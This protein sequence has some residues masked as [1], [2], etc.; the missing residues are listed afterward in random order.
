[1]KSFIDDILHKWPPY[2]KYLFFAIL[3]ATGFPSIYIFAFNDYFYKPFAVSLYF[4][5]C[6]AF[7]YIAENNKIVKK[8]KWGVWVENIVIVEA[9]LFLLF[10]QKHFIAAAIIVALLIVF[11]AFLPSIYSKKY[12]YVRDWEKFLTYCRT[13]ASAVMCILI[14]VVLLVPSVIGFCDEY[15]TNIKKDNWQKYVDSFRQSETGAEDDKPF[16]KH[17]ATVMKLRDWDELN[18]DERLDLMRKIAIIEAER[19]G[20]GNISEI[21][22]TSGKASEYTY[23]YYSQTKKNIT[24]NVQHLDSG[25]M[26]D[27]L[28]SLL[29]EVFHAYEYYVIDNTDFD[30]EI[31]K[32]SYYYKDARKWK[33][34][35]EK[36]CPAEVDY[37]TYRAQPLEA[38]ARKY[39][40]ERVLAYINTILS[41]S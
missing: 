19:L 2:F 7:L 25:R 4:I 6:I 20:I 28:N 35:D 29:H 9:F 31:V 18:S 39:A 12:V 21:T 14:A 23:A 27:V 10:A 38:D 13:K 16:G 11:G 5:F 3:V 22:I 40:E 8:S 37:E 36:Y 15:V 24:I 34:N 26:Q 30:S 1:M 17:Y 33:A 32:T 41:T